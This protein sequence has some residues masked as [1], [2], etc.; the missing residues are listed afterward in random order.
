MVAIVLFGIGVIPEI[1]LRVACERWGQR[2]E[3]LRALAVSAAHQRSR[4]R[5]LALYRLTAGGGAAAVAQEMG[6]HEQ[7]VR[8]WVH[9]YNAGGPDAV[10]YRQTGGR[11]PF[12]RGSKPPW[13]R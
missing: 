7:S 2:P 4:E 10:S 9:A 11:R 3:D 5:F 6:R 12:V 13:G 1:M 8:K